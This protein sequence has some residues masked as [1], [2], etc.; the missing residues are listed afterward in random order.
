[1]KHR[2]LVATATL[3]IFAIHTFSLRASE[4][5]LPDNP[6]IIVNGH[7]HIEQVPDKAIL[8]FEV[9]AIA[10][11]FSLAKQSVDEIISRAIKAA[12]KNHVDEDDINASK[13]NASPQY[14]WHEKT[15]S[16]KGERVSRQVEVRLTNIEHYNSLVEGLLK[17][18]ISRLQPVELDFSD[19]KSLES[20]ALII[21]LDD[22]K[23]RANTM[24]EHLGT[25]LKGIFQIAPL[26][27]NTMVSRMAM[28]ATAESSSDK[29]PL[30]PGKQTIRQQ[31]RVIYLL[32]N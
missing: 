2:I 25:K 9:S 23:R 7:G 32:D 1:M 15:R 27:H 20:K 30:K 18:G 5:P 19:R 12:K 4:F 26:E 6:H 21:A 28:R 31:I 14:D 11:N 16:Y 3:L 24:A 13:I 8:R 29:A 10:A 22:A 17:S